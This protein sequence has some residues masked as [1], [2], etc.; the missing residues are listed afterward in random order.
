MYIEEKIIASGLTLIFAIVVWFTS[1]PKGM[2]G[3]ANPSNWWWGL[4][5]YL[6]NE[7][8]TEKKYSK[9]IVS[10]FFI[11]WGLS[12]WIFPDFWSHKN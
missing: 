8:G 4:S 11:L 10:L 5:S 6:F 12:F 7:D 9:L 1:H 2:K 3:I